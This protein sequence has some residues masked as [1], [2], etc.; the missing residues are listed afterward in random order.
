MVRK[1]NFI[2]QSAM[3]SMELTFEFLDDIHEELPHLIKVVPCLSD[4]STPRTNFVKYENFLLL[5]DRESV[6]CV[7]RLRP[8]PSPESLDILPMDIS[9]I[10]YW[11]PCQHVPF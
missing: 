6:Q 5:N 7:S 8:S 10:S 11:P 1:S 4:Y 3:R 9:S 2:L